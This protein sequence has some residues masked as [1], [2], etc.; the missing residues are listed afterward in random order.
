M[1]FI[2]WLQKLPI[3]EWISDSTF[4]FP[5]VLSV[6]SIGMGI[7]VGLLIMLD[8]RVL[9]FR[10][11]V[12]LVAFDRLMGLAWIGFGINAVSGTLLFMADGERLIVNW[13]FLAKMVCVVLGGASALALWKALREPAPADEASGPALIIGDGR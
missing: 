2:S 5:L 3:S 1:Q 12:P 4:G 13:P 11:D 9:G 6:H 10:K 7:V 8:I